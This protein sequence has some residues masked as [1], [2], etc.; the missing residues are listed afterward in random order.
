[1]DS[2]ANIDSQPNL[3]VLQSFFNKFATMLAMK[4]LS[5]ERL[6]TM[7][8]ECSSEGRGLWCCSSKQIHAFFHLSVDSGLV[9]LHVKLMRLVGLKSANS[10]KWLVFLTKV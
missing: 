10:G 2:A 4:P 9:E 7:L 6:R 8:D 5:F 1:M 3:A